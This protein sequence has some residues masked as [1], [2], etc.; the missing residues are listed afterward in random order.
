MACFI[1]LSIGTSVGTVVALAPVAAGVT[2]NL[3]IPIGVCLGAVVGGA[4]FGDNLSMISD[5][6]IAAT[7][8][9]QVEMNRKFYANIK[10]VIPAAHPDHTAV[11]DFRHP[12]RNR[13]AGQ[14]DHLHRLLQGWRHTS[15]CWC[16]RC[17]ASM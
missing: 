2:Q 9:Q 12:R 1:S 17:S 7:R 10:I 15:Q 13:A 11:P 3:G 4:M 6:T 14:A 8:T 5:T 16:W